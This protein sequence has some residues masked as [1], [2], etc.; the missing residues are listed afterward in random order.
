MWTLAAVTA[1][2]AASCTD[3]DDPFDDP[4]DPDGADEAGVTSRFASHDPPTPGAAGIGDP[5]YPTLGNGG[6]DVERYELELRYETAAPDQA[7]DGTVEI[8]ARATQAL[9][10]FNLDFAGDGVGS[11]T[12]NGEPASWVRDGDELVITPADPLRKGKRFRVTIAHFVTTPRAPDP[13]VFLGAPFFMT[14]DGSAWAAQP[15]GA[16]E[17]FPSND[18]PRDKAAFTFRVDVP[19]G[20]T[21]VANGELDDHDT[22]GGREIWSYDQDEPMATELAQVAVGALTV[23]SRGNHHG[24]TVRDVVPAHLADALEPKL[25]VVVDQLEWLEDLLGH[26]PFETYGSLAVDASFG[27]ALETQT[28]SLYETAFFDAPPEGYEP[29]MVHELAH[30]WFG[31]SVAPAA[32]SDLW[33]NE[34]HATWYEATSQVDIDG[35]FAQE[36]L[37]QLYAL[38]DLF[39][40]VFGPVASPLSGDPEQLFSPQ[41][42]A[43]GA[44]VLYALRQE[45]GDET[46]RKIER[47]WVKKYRGESATTDDF[48][49]LAS[50]V[51]HQDLTKFLTDWLY[52]TTTPPM[53]GH[54]EWTVDPFPPGATATAAR[55]VPVESLFLR[56]MHR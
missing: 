6:Y 41:V 51:A 44:L 52:G 34:G 4:D 53:P 26:Y 29:I 55:A 28:L 39:R 12:V 17:I 43:G 7:I 47:R 11:V 21:A 42:Y 24:V 49:E 2:F 46:F 1:L 40:A 33:L 37:R 30:Q 16:H 19:A 3:P 56:S 50:D 54:P 38:G 27:F 20:T 13:D 8:K 25:A 23:I 48:I 14:A 32:W 45:V 10:R 9:S 22:A 36:Q 18:H 5:L 31:N 35:E 15:A